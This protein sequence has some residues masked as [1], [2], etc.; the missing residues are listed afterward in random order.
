MIQKIYSIYDTKAQAFLPPFFMPNDDMA[1]RAVMDC[2]ADPNH[3]FAAHPED[4][5]LVALGEFD[6][7]LGD[8]SGGKIHLAELGQLS[9]AV[10]SKKRREE[11]LLMDFDASLDEMEKDIN[12]QGHS[13]DDAGMRRVVNGK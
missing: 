13:Y 11:Q 1:I 6:D 5:G 3:N 8:V 4:Y 12:N 9:M 10:K 7:Q 2:L